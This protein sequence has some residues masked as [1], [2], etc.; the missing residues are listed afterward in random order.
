MTA[1]AR[2]LA[3][4]YLRISNDAEG[5]ELGVNRQLDDCRALADRLGFTVAREYTDN[6][7]GASTR[8]R[9]SPKKK[10]TDYLAMCESARAG[11]LSAIIAYSN[12][13]L[14]RRPAELEDVI[15]LHEQTGVRVLTVVSGEDD[16]STADGRMVARIKASV[17]AAEVEKLS[18]RMVRRN[19]QA[20]QMGTATGSGRRP[21]GWLVGNKYRDADPVESNLIRAAVDAILE[22][23][24]V[25]RVTM[26]WNDHGITTSTGKPWVRGVLTKLL[27]SPRLAGWQIYR[28]EIATDKD[29]KPVKGDHEPILDQATHDAVV[30]KLTNQGGPVNTRGSRPGK[31]TYL[32]SGI[33]RCGV[34]AAKMYANAR[35][36]KRGVRRH[37]YV[38]MQQVTNPRHTVT[39]S[40]Q[41]LDR[42]VTLAVAGVLDRQHM[43][44][45]APAPFTGGARLDQIGEQIG[46]L[47]AAFRAGQLSGPLVFGQVEELEK[48]RDQLRQDRRE[49]EA[50]A[51]AEQGGKITADDFLALDM[52]RKRAVIERRLEAVVL[53]PAKGQGGRH[54]DPSRVSLVW[55]EGPFTG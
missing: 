21:F 16:L 39:G 47:M 50:E 38:C 25:N 14:T 15:K 32:L 30:A 37:Y 6:D 55:R 11:E 9:V 20:A 42:D 33:M 49:H 45:P 1:A 22:G 53:A 17:D 41:V 43:E 44:A 10:R 46:E 28:G 3:A 12:G 35:T 2:P 51:L 54:F 18:E 26:A 24:P 5:K 23:V 4:I 48:E 8:T 40:G 52:D 31:R 19:L 29:G 27:K 13:R 36:D 7:K 34:C